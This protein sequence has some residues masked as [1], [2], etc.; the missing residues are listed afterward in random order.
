MNIIYKIILYIQYDIINIIII[1]I[2]IAP[3][4]W[5]PLSW[6]QLCLFLGRHLAVN[7]ILRSPTVKN[8]SGAGH[9]PN[10]NGFLPSGKLT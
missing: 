5:F 2:Y 9:V 7:Y 4:S 8:N 6:A 3:L 1:Y 10:F